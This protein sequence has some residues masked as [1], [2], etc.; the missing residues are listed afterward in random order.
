[1]LRFFE[2]RIFG[3]LRI[4]RLEKQLRAHARSERAE[5]KL[6]GTKLRKQIA[7]ID[8]KIKAQVIALEEGVEPELV[9]ARIKELRGEKEVLVAALAEIGTEREE[10]ED[11][12]LARQL[13]RVPDLA[14]SLA[15]ATPA[16]QRQVFEAF[17]L[18][19]AYDKVEGRIEVSVTMSEAVA[20]AFEGTKALQKEGS[21]VVPRDIAGARFVS[22]DHPRISA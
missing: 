21:M 5:V 19:I 4:E 14:K 22:R 20:N 11:E 2:Q 3:P 16:M 10:A 9:S 18:R 13:Q 15:E 6:A 12:E 8:R 7:E 1:M 17:E